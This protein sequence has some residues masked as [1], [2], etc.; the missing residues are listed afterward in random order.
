M[1]TGYQ[2]VAQYLTQNG[3]HVTFFIPDIYKNEKNDDKFEVKY[4]YSRTVRVFSK[5]NLPNFAW[6]FILFNINLSSPTCNTTV[7]V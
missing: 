6:P 7:S 4:Y 5:L 3:Y 2:K 1:N